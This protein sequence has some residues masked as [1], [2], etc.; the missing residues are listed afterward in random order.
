MLKTIRSKSKNFANLFAIA[1]LCGFVLALMRFQESYFLESALFIKYEAYT[2]LLNTSFV[3]IKASI[4]F[5]VLLFPFVFL[6][7]DIKVIATVFYLIVIFCNSLLIKYFLTNFDLLGDEI[8]NFSVSE[9]LFIAHTEKSTIHLFEL[10]LFILYPIFFIVL[11]YLFHTF[12]RNISKKTTSVCLLIYFVFL[13]ASA[14]DYKYY[15]PMF[16]NFS[17]YQKFSIS[18]NKISYFIAEV[19]E[20]KIKNTKKTSVKNLKKQIE[21]YQNSN[22]QFSY[23]NKQFPLLH[24]EE[25]TNVL[26]PFFEK[27]SIK[28]NIVF[29]LVESLSRSFSGANA[30]LGSFTP[31]LDSLKT[32][33]LYWENFF[34]NAERTYGV[35][36]NV[37]S[38]AP[39]FNQFVSNKV[40]VNHSSIIT[41][42]KQQSYHTDFHYGGW[43]GFSSRG[44]FVRESKIDSVY[45][46]AAFDTTIFK[47]HESKENDFH[48]GYDDKALFEQ[49]FLHTKNTKE[50]FL[51]IILTLSMHSPYDVSVNYSIKDAKKYLGDNL[52]NYQNQLFEAHP[53][54]IKSIAFSD[55]YLKMFFDDFKKRDDFE[56]TIFV[57]LGDHNIHSLP[58]KN[59]LD[60]FHVPLLIYSDLLK[61]TKTFKGVS[62]HRA[63]TPSILGLLEGN[64]EME[65][66]AEKHWLAY[67]LDTSI[68]FQ[69]KVNTPMCL[70]SSKY[71]SYLYQ[72]NFV[73]KNQVYKF[74][75][76]LNISK[77]NDTII[78]NKV[79]KLYKD[80]TDIE[81]YMNKNDKLMK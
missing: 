40:Y 51:S 5:S 71:I 17:S 12:F 46:K 9:M 34:S 22:P 30:H 41:E 69:S 55:E 44:K 2:L 28:P 72:N 52:S 42:L 75:S 26:G 35:L 29:V 79:L 14:V 33:S 74:D 16:S 47:A 11:V 68:N 43:E 10:V 27:K 66:E 59:E 23:T 38:S 65:F 3:D 32:K 60:I 25:Y 81:A 50:P 80:Y 76:L 39:Y 49:Y 4:V 15:L 62:T 21:N 58:I 1:L 7:K 24:N 78:G 8:F 64:F 37:L 45:A 13:I 48:W 61:T 63:L 31:F 20:T 70:S 77:Q 57:L 54:K 67:E 56:N 6:L 53:K 36:P 19:I 73:F 18:N